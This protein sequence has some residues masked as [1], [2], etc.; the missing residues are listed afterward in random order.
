MLQH[1]N[2]LKK[3]AA[4][5]LCAA[6]VFGIGAI[7]SAALA[8]DVIINTGGA[9]VT[10]DVP[11]FAERK[12]ETVV[13]QQFDFSCGS[14]A[15]ATI[16][17]HHYDIAISETDA[18]KAMW[19]VGDQERIQELGFS[20][21]E[22]KSYLEKLDLLADGFKLTL[23]RINE[24]GV[25]GI[26]LIDVSGYKHFVV[27]KGMTEKTVL[28]GDPSKGVY[29]LSRKE[30]EKHWD[31]IILFIRS[32][33]QRGKANFNRAIDWRL[34]PSSPYDRAKDVETLQSVSLHQTRPSFSG[35]A[36][37]TDLRNP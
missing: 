28:V 3:T 31:G 27:I 16:L 24:I 30:F 29:S 2:S 15:L 13:R 32:D 8:S 18:F 19:E 34:A 10:V 21:L 25:P 12:F 22:M 33:V 4:A 20:L 7:P 35:F 6:P 9:N 17:T 11:S 23:D 14:A 37:S 5:L 36:I 1:F 26:A